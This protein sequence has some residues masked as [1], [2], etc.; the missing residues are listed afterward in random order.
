MKIQVYVIADCIAGVM[1]EIKVTTCA[2]EAQF[3]VERYMTDFD[4]ETESIETSRF[5]IDSETL[6]VYQNGQEY[7]P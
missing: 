5:E 6:G 1:N 3:A 7:H 4:E 2:K